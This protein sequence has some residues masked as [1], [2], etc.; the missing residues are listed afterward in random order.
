MVDE[1]ILSIEETT[2]P[3]FKNNNKQA[4]QPKA[5]PKER[6]LTKTHKSWVNSGEQGSSL[7]ELMK[8]DHGTYY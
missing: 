8:S 5:K 1:A 4:Y 2:K 7:N 6:E 3:T